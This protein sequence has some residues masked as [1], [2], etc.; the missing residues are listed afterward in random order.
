MEVR[1][2]LFNRVVLCGGNT[3]YTNIAE[4]LCK[5]MKDLGYT[6]IQFKIFV[7]A[8]RMYTVWIGGSVISS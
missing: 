4:R 1:R 3:M 6:S 5:K 7:P 2:T 8:E